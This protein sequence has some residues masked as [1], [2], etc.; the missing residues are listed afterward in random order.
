MTAPEHFKQ[1]RQQLLQ[2]VPNHSAIIVEAASMSKRNNDV[3]YPFRQNSDFYYLTGF[4]EPDAVLLLLHD[5]KGGH[6]ILFNRPRDPEFEVWDGPRAGQEGAIVE[7]GVDAAYPI[8]QLDQKMAEFFGL[9]ERVYFSFSELTGLSEHIMAWSKP[10]SA[11]RQHFGAEKFIDLDLLLHHLRLIKRPEE[12]AVLEKASEIT[13]EA[14]KRA[15]QFTRPGLMEYEVAA[16][17][18]HEFTRSGC[19]QPAYNTIVGGGENSCVLHYVNNDKPLRDGD[20]LLVDAGAEYLN[21]ASDVTR[22]YPINGR[23]SPAQKQIYE[24]VLRAQTAVIESIRPGVLW[25]ELQKTAVEVIT[26]GLVELGLLTGAV[27][28]LIKNGAYKQFYMHGIG[29]WLGMDVHDVG[30]Y[31]VQ[32]IS[33][34]LEENMVFTVEPG[35]YIAKQS[36]VDEKWWNIGVRIEDDVVVTAEGCRVLTQ[37]LPKTV[38]DIEQLMAAR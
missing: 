1:R 16:E 29:H 15:I 2:L 11:R 8:D 19:Q 18:Q 17:I 32:G 36:G 5:D 3:E 13:V 25:N 14:H 27:D 35:I 28:L 10:R 31:K 24:L 22:T 37:G 7:Y 9:V 20:L 26:T 4:N 23:F 33:R 38:A 21:Y 6:S 34:S 12:I 30:S